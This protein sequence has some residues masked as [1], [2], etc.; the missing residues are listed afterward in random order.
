VRSCDGG[1]VG[2]VEQSE[3]DGVLA[4]P[5]ESL[6]VLAV[7]QEVA[8]DPKGGAHGQAVADRPVA[9]RQGV[10][11]PQAQ[12]GAAGLAA[13]GDVE[14]VGDGLEVAEVRHEGRGPACDDGVGGA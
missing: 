4:D 7:L 12:V 11:D 13:P 8:H 6:A 5:G 3:A 2:G 10:A 9:G 1:E 14:L